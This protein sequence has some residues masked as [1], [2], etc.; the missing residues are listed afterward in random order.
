[1]LKIRMATYWHLVCELLYSGTQPTK[2]PRN[3][4]SRIDTPSQNMGNYCIDQLSGWVQVVR[5][6]KAVMGRRVGLGELVTEVSAAGFPI[7]EKLA[8]P[9]AVL[10]PIEAHVNGF[11][12]FLFDCAVGEAFRGGVVDADW[13]RWLQVPE[14]CEGCAYR[15]S[16]LTIM[17]GGADFGF[18][19]QRHHV[20]E[21]IGDGVDRAVERGVG[22]R[23]IGR[24]SGLVAKELV[25][26]YADAGSGLGNLGDIT[27]EMQDRVTGAVA[28]SGVGVGHIIIWEPNGGV[29]VFFA[30]LSIVGKQWRQWQRAC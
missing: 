9:S 28:D 19:S 26:T 17:E 30:L 20:V 25:A 5:A 10:D 22:D 29:T 8:F 12:Y 4:G 24:V 16:F 15:H 3:P 14:L 23:W 11:G 27:V 21:N 6:H 13:I 2:S 7:N 18:S 1:M